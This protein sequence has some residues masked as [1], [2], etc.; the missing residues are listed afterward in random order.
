MWQTNDQVDWRHLHE[1]FEAV[2]ERNPAV[3]I[4]QVSFSFS[5]SC[6]FICFHQLLTLTS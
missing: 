3:S 4:S 1:I 6:L 2:V 5:F